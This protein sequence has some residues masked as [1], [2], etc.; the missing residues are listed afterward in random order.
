MA[1]QSF[2]ALSLL[3]CPLAIC[4]DNVTIG[5]IHRI[6]SGGKLLPSWDKVT[7][8]G[9][10]AIKHANER[11]GTI[12]AAFANLSKRYISISTDS[13]SVEKGTIMGYRTCK[14]A[15]VKG[16]VGPARSATNIQAGYLGALD[17]LVSIGTWTS[18]P[19]LS[20][21]ATFP[22]L[23]R[24]FHSDTIRAAR[25]VETIEYFNWTR[26]AIV[27]VDDAWAN[28]IVKEVRTLVRD[29][30][31]G[32]LSSDKPIVMNTFSFYYNHE[33]S[34]R[35]AVQRLSQMIQPVYIVLAIVFDVDAEYLCDE[36]EKLGLFTPQ[37]VWIDPDGLTTTALDTAINRT[38]FGSRL[39]GWLRV[40]T[41]LPA[42][43]FA[44]Y[45][46][47]WSNMTSAACA[48]PY[49]TP[50]PSMFAEAPA[51]LGAYEYDA[52]AA[53]V[54]A[55]D[56]LTEAEE[57]DGDAVRA[58]VGALDFSGASGRIRFYSNLDRDLATAEMSLMNI[59]F[60]PEENQLEFR[61][62]R[63]FRKSETI[64]SD[65]VNDDVSNITFDI[66]FVAPIVWLRNSSVQPVDLTTVIPYHE[67]LFLD[68]FMR[69]A[70]IGLAIGS[71]VV[72]LL[73]IVWTIAHR[74]AAVVKSA[75]PVFLV[76]IAAGVFITLLAAYPLSRDHRG[77]EPD[78][79]GR[80]E[81]LDSACA[82][83]M[84]FYVFG[85]D[86]TYGSLLAKL[87]RVK[88][89]FLNRKIGQSPVSISQMLVC[90]LVPVALDFVVMV[91]LQTHSPFYYEVS[92]IARDP[93]GRPTK[94]Y[95]QCTAPENVWVYLALL[96]AAHGL[97]LI[98]ANFL[99][100]QLRH[101]P[102]EY[103]EGKYV[104]IS[105]ANN[106]QT[107]VIALMLLFLVVESPRV[108]YSTK[109]FEVYWSS[110]VTL[111]MMFVPK[112]ILVHFNDESDLS[113]AN[114]A[115]KEAKKSRSLHSKMPHLAGIFSLRNSWA[116]SNRPS[117]GPHSNDFSLPPSKAEKV[118]T[119]GRDFI[120]CLERGA[121]VNDW[122]AR[123]AASL[124]GVPAAGKRDDQ[125]MSL[126]RLL[127]QGEHLN[128][129]TKKTRF[130]QKSDCLETQRS[131]GPPQASHREPASRL[132][133]ARQ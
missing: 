127:V 126:V 87:W 116:S 55:L 123:A 47:G 62:V 50:S 7:C 40:T 27:H 18:S 106:L 30:D 4:A 74:D 90:V 35:L 57:S 26:F 52:A 25:M 108:T 15:G 10:M 21:T 107:S 1:P 131:D 39:H 61:V 9:L 28:Q 71:G 6:S 84:W 3:L 42:P 98:F 124:D 85:F 113:L 78:A 128:T 82:G 2:L 121:T 103:N 125:A 75:Q 44:R 12:V 112:V 43:N 34:V 104:G 122:L 22:Y 81:S 88:K 8:A 133:D 64:I 94:S 53:M 80:Y 96:I 86:I 29:P 48:N 70:F 117:V 45:Y 5:F 14:A 110:T 16:I 83:A 38:A 120:G 17:K 46:A 95:G 72:A 49:F 89:I 102:S 132:L 130:N 66:I 114:Q 24:V 19:I 60:H 54:L 101:V 77:L 11:D 69:S 73:C 63:I 115:L 119:L 68:S 13:E 56:S 109:F 51:D 20:D 91:V 99:V 105:L 93:Y 118:V 79:N 129:I 67:K 32:A 92:V 37:H 41:T 59:I 76:L 111:L 31:S 65:V 23:A 97:L 36:A 33:E 58:A 100:Y